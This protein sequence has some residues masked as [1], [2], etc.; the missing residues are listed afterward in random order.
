[1]QEINEGNV[2]N[3]E[4]AMGYY[5]S[6]KKLGLK[7]F[8]SQLK[9][10]LMDY[11]KRNKIE[12]Q[13]EI[14]KRTFGN[15]LESFG[16]GEISPLET[17]DLGGSSALGSWLPSNNK[18]GAGITVVTNPRGPAFQKPEASLGMGFALPSNIIPNLQQFVSDF[19]T[20]SGIE[21]E[22]YKTE[23]K[24]F[25]QNPEEDTDMT[26]QSTNSA[27]SNYVS[28]NLKKTLQK[29][30]ALLPDEQYVQDPN[31]PAQTYHYDPYS[32]SVYRVGKFKIQQNDK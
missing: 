15:M 17:G 18:T 25:E 28:Q 30:G 20:F 1:M 21:G 6:P 3:V 10:Q 2:Y 14:I 12:N 13:E 26:W 5:L 16:V 31:A 4:D 9:S 7:N 29:F 27:V 23:R 24:A 19:K 32:R 22:K 8:K 11:F